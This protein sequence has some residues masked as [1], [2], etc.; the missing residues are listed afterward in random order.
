MNNEEFLAHYGILGMKWGKRKS[1]AQIRADAR[2]AA[3]KQEFKQQKQEAKAKLQKSKLD[4]RERAAKIRFD[5]ER[6]RSSK[7]DNNNKKRAPITAAKMQRRKEKEERRRYDKDVKDRAKDA[8]VK[9]KIE[10]KK[11]R[12]ITNTKLSPNDYKHMSDADL[13]QVITRMNME[14]SYKELNPKQKPAWMKALG[15]STV[16]LPMAQLL[17]DDDIAKKLLKRPLNVKEK[18]MIDIAN[19]VVGAANESKRKKKENK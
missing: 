2:R 18:S 6:A 7:I 1:T 4:V 9:A 3:A 5:E 8:K 12:N 10:A 16:A 14:K 15:V 11:D 13:K 19:K 17:K